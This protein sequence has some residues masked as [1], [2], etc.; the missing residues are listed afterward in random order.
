MLEI[1]Q[2]RPCNGVATAPTFTGGPLLGLTAGL[3]LELHFGVELTENSS[4][5]SA[6]I[7]YNYKLKNK[8]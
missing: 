7:H 2:I 4:R 5:D 1:L 6:R 3:T 8:F